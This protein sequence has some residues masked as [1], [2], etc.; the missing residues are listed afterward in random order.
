MKTGE[1]KKKRKE[2]Q[3]RE[4]AGITGLSACCSCYQNTHFSCPTKADG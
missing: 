3:A 2:W 1:K 4:Q